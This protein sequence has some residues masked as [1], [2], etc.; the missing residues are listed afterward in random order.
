M[1]TLQLKMVVL[2]SLLEM[3][4]SDDV[5]GK[6]FNLSKVSSFDF[7]FELVSGDKKDGVNPPGSFGKCCIKENLLGAE[8]LVNIMACSTMGG[9]GHVV[10]EDNDDGG[11]DDYVSAAS[12]R[13]GT[14][15]KSKYTKE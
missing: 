11:N 2:R 15:F 14:T 3:V 6:I 13:Y 4:A 8:N 5:N 7:T 12:T 1:I 10:V 9:I